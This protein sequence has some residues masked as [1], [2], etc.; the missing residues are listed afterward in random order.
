MVV[1]RINENDLGDYICV[2]QNNMGAEN[3]SI[4]L[5]YNPE[6]PHLHHIEQDDDTVITHWHIRSL[7]PLTE[8]MLNYR[9]KGVCAFISIV[10][11]D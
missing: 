7:Q 1:N 8:V 11:F 3:V 9:Q 4:E 2:V 10:E 6:P 5:T